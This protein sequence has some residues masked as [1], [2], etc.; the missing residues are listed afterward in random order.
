MDAPERL[1]EIRFISTIPDSQTKC[2][3]ANSLHAK[4]QLRECGLGGPLAK[5]RTR[6]NLSPSLG[7]RLGAIMVVRGTSSAH[8]SVNHGKQAR[9]PVSAPVIGR[10]ESEYVARAVASG[11]VSSIGPFIDEFES[12]FAEAI[13]VS[14]AIAVSNGTAALH[15][16]LHAVGV[17]PGDEVVVPD[18]TFAATAHAVL[19][20]GAKPV[21]VDVD[22]VTWCLRPHLV[23]RALSRR[24]K[25]VIAVHLYGHPADIPALRKICSPGGIALVE[26]A[27]EAL[28][29]SIEAV[30]AGALGDVA[31]FSFYGNKTI[32]T[33]EGGMVTTND[34][35]LAERIRF[36]KDHGM[37]PERRYYHS[38]LA[39]NCRMTNM[40]AA[41]GVA[42]I[43][44][45]GDFL[46]HK[47]RIF[48]GYATG[49]ADRPEV[50]LNPVTKGTTNGFWM[51]CLL[52]DQNWPGARDAFAVELLRQGI[53]TR[54]F[55]LPMS[56]LPHLSKFARV[57]DSGAD[58]PIARG[59]S[60]RG[61]NLP[62]GC[63]LSD[64][65]VASIA[66]AVTATITEGSAQQER[67]PRAKAGEVSVSSAMAAP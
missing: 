33:G 25:A 8:G 16:A 52:L 23:E 37:S 18:L 51:S 50:R 30:K 19:M 58:C 55:F 41:L 53:D 62:S 10:I 21:F 28:G 48:A 31:A 2:Q 57:G 39:F 3:P 26:D 56:S 44:Q 60:A 22:P 12:R 40:Q 47:R 42:Q 14:E 15:L 17:G 34:Q 67:D 1:N 27:A 20:T 36:L 45:L 49:L 64:E 11:W 35:R 54:P 65:D 9:Y 7:K 46:A 59:L 63:G 5:R 6:C 13:G 4:P 24:T 32:T 38:E 43:I 61:L 66:A 29:T